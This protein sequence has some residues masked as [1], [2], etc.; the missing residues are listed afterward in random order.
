MVIF[1]ELLSYKNYHV[2]KIEGDVPSKSN[3]EVN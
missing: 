2:W 1:L 3:Y